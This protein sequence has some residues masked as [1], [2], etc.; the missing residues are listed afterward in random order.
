[1][2]V[3]SESADFERS[4]LCIVTNLFWIRRIGGGGFGAGILHFST[5]Q[6]SPSNVVR[7]RVLVFYCYTASPACSSTAEGSLVYR[8]AIYCTH[9]YTGVCGERRTFISLKRHLGKIFRHIFM[10]LGYK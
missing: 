6:E 7:L 9:Y 1:M 8:S 3:Y 10:I 4:T 5:V 2:A